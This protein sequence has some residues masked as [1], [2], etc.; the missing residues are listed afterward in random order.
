MLRQVQSG[1]SQGSNLVSS[2]NLLIDG[3]GGFKDCFEVEECLTVRK[4]LWVKAEPFYLCFVHGRCLRAQLFFS[5]RVSTWFGVR[6]LMLF[7]C[8]D[9]AG[10]FLFF[11]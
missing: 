3:Q 6:S 11:S 1:E 5:R 7:R 2:I 4:N 10:V 9:D 8:V